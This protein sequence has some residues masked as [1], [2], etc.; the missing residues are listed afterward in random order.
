M[1]GIFDSRNVY[2]RLDKRRLNYYRAK[3]DSRHKRSGFGE[4]ERSAILEEM[5]EGCL[6]F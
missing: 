4:K 2:A 5:V 6:E 1:L 3:V